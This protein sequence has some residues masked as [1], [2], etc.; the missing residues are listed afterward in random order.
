MYAADNTKD[1]GP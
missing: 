1:R